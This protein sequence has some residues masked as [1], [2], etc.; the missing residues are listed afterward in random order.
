MTEKENFLFYF[1]GRNLI[2]YTHLTSILLRLFTLQTFG[3]HVIG[4]V[5]TSFK[6]IQS[7]FDTPFPSPRINFLVCTI[8]FRE[9]KQY[10]IA[11]DLNIYGFHIRHLC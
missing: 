2:D 4:F 9:R 6:L 7:Q 8:F 3:L 11:Q 1:R 10:I 5:K